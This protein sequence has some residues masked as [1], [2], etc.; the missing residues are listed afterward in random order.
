MAHSWWR[1]DLDA[2]CRMVRESAKGGRNAALNRAAFTMGQRLHWND[3]SRVEAESRL[4]AEARGV[5]LTESEA[6]GTIASGLTSGADSPRALPASSPRGRRRRGARAK[7]ERHSVQQP[8]PAPKPPKRLPPEEVARVWNACVPLMDCPDAVRWLH[9]GRIDDEWATMSDVARAL[10]PD[11]V[12]LPTWAH[13]WRSNQR[14]IVFAVYDE[15]GALVGL[16]GR[17]TRQARDKGEAKER[18]PKGQQAPGLYADVV[19][20]RLLAGETDA[21]EWVAEDGAVIIV[22]G[23]RDVLCWASRTDSDARALA[24]L[25]VWQGAWGPEYAAAIPDGCTVLLATDN[26]EKGDSYAAKIRG[27]LTGR[28]VRVVRVIPP[29][30]FGDWGDVARHDARGALAVMDVAQVKAWA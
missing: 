2:A 8:A 14:G 4:L 18:G 27:T 10:P 21:R 6:R 25:G 15:S 16:R 5:G 29:A 9:D 22:E 7:L 26:D 19:G 13:W 1:E 24:V 20:R 3:A 17:L 11:G 30:G 12:W 23:G 28:K